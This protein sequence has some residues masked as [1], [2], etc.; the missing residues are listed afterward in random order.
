M[1]RPVAQRTVARAGNVLADLVNR[2]EFRER[3]RE[4]AVWNV[5]REVVGDLLASKA[6]PIRI[7]GGKLFVHVANSTWMQELQFLKDEIRTRL[8]HRLEGPVVR[9]IFLILG[10]AKPRR[11]KAPSAK[12]HPV[13]ESAIAAL[14]PSIDKPE[15]EAALRRV[16]RARARRFG[17]STDWP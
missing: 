2:L 7:E 8:N 3:L 10:A 16:A 15:I 17:P 14:V 4:Y 5:W 11:K 12:L 6:E 9:E 1:L 13:D